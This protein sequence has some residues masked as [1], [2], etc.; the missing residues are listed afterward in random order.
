MGEYGGAK[1]G[2]HDDENGCEGVGGF[3]GGNGGE[4]LTLRVKVRRLEEKQLRNVSRRMLSIL[5]ILISLTH[6]QEFHRRPR[7]Q[8]LF[9]EPDRAEMAETWAFG[10]AFW[11]VAFTL[12]S[13]APL[14]SYNSKLFMQN[15]L[16]HSNHF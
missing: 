5:S 16:I 1:S 12:V 10:D 9:S 4:T 2:C 11:T 15:M 7:F 6:F 3:F 8:K 14:C 13:S